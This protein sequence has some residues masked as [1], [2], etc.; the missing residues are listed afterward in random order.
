LFAAVHGG[1]VGGE[2]GGVVGQVPDSSQL[3]ELAVT[4]AEATWESSPVAPAVAVFLV[5][6]SAAVD[7]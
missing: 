3:G 6:P 1:E 4:V 7:E 2:V 5:V